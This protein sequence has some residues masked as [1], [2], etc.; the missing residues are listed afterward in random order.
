MAGGGVC[1][2]RLAINA[3]TNSMSNE[4]E[5]LQAKQQTKLLR[6]D[7]VLNFTKKRKV[8]TWRG[9]QHANLLP[10]LEKELRNFVG[11]TPS[12]KAE[13]LRK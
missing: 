5:K 12:G 9:K 1:G 8:W 6:K 13:R 11:G 10:K 2:N 4:K 3:Q 7:E